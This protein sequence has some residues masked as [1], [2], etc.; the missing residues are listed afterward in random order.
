M[1]VAIIGCGN[2]GVSIAA[3]L[4]IRGHNVSLIKTS[5]PNGPVFDRLLEKKSILIK[6]NGTYSTGII[7]NISHDLCSVSDSEMVILTTQSTYHDRV[8][9]DMGKY[10]RK[11]QTVVCICSYMSSFYFMKHCYELPVIVETTGPYLE[12]RTDVCDIPEEVVF[13]VGCRLSKV[14]VS[15]FNSCDP[16]ET[17]R[18]I[19]EL[20]PGFVYEYNTIESA[21]LNP[22]MV[23][24]T[25][26]SIMSISR[27]E[28]SDG[29]F[30]MYR[31]AYSRKNESIVRLMLALDKEKMDV[32]KSLRCKPVDILTASGFLGDKVES[33][34]KYS[35]SEDRAKSPSSVT[36]RYITEDVPQGLVLMESIAS[37]AGVSV[38]ITSSLINIS[39]AAL[40]CD[41]RSAGRTLARLGATGFIDSIIDNAHE[42]PE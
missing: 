41:F 32:L 3:D 33:F 10:L 19:Q 24:H 7:G 16:C 13:R 36:S 22:N 34:Y 5:F 12:G 31:E 26:G 15:L 18:K 21:L 8:I 29:D 23:L 25:V 30:C 20:Y 4:S 38:P 35:E 1:N 39:G 27:I 11:N 42:C 14:P 17:M 37:R 2:V 9:G 40:G 28:Y 6:E